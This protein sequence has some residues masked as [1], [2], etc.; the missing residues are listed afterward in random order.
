LY[1]V[2]EDWRAQRVKE[3]AGIAAYACLNVGIFEEYVAG[4]R[5]QPAEKSGFAGTPRPCHD[6]RGKVSRCVQQHAC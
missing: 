4:F 1:L 5:E 2:E 3:R 6:N